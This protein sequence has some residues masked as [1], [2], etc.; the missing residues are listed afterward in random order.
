MY[1]QADLETAV[2]A[3]ET[4]VAQQE[5]WIS[6]QATQIGAQQEMIMVLATRQPA[7]QA[8][9]F[10]QNGTITLT[11]FHPV[12]GAVLIHEG[13]CCVGSQA[14]TTI[15]VDV[16]FEAFSVNGEIVEMRV[17]LGGP[18]TAQ[19]DM[20]DAPWEPFVAEKRYPVSVATNWTS[21]WVHV[22]YRDGSGVP[23][24]IY[25]DEIAVEGH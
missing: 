21:F 22:Q 15:E 5:E 11:P 24:P 2:V 7:G 14:G 1:G 4:Q 9:G 19:S 6:Y 13:A 12:S 10:P 20:S 18:L 23:S 8:D 25:S 16:Q 3:L 17:L